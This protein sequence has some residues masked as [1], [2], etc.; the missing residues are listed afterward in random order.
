MIP[1]HTLLR[2]T[3]AVSPTRFVAIEMVHGAAGSTAVGR[4]RN[5]WSPVREGRDFDFTYSLKPLE[6]LRGYVT[7]ISDTELKNA[8]SL[9]PLETGDGADHAR[10][11]AVFL[12]AAH[13]KLTAGP[14]IQAGPSIDQLLAAR[15]G[16]ETRLP[17]LQLCIED[18][19]AL[20][21]ECGNGYSCWY[22]STISWASPTRPLPVERNPRLI[23]E[24]LFGTRSAMVSAGHQSASASILD[25]ISGDL[26]RLRGRLGSADS[27]DVDDFLEE[28]RAV[29]RRIQEIESPRARADR[30]AVLYGSPMGDSHVHDHR[31]LP[32]F[33]AGR[34]NGRI[35]GNLHLRC[36]E[37][38]PMAN[39]LLTLA[40]RLGLEL[41]RIGDSTG[42]VAL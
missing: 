42:D 4:A 32:L 11:S 12:T 16:H 13:P 29:E 33:V 36:A 19:E 9:A 10:S 24:R 22:T 27:V 40:H 39:M 23:F 17:S 35:K 2:R 8:M 6:P 41:E 20:P 38:T 18:L 34:A 15:W 1:A 37:G 26:T 14:D 30:A 31:F 3:A 28:V 7:V 5:Y 25:D 21:D